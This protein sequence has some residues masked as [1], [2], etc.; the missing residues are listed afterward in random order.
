MDQIEA[1]P[2]F[3]ILTE[4]H[5]LDVEWAGADELLLIWRRRQEIREFELALHQGL[6]RIEP[7]SCLR[8]RDSAVLKLGEKRL[9]LGK[10]VEVVRLNQA[11]K[12][13]QAGVVHT[14]PFNHL[15]EEQRLD[16]APKTPPESTSLA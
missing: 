9:R 14:S 8:F 12:L 15:A 11:V 2:K 7:A 6:N 10:A 4:G 5:E 3:R 13:A 1:G 16:E